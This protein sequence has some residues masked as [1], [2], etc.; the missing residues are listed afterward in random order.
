[1]ELVKTFTILNV[2]VDTRLEI[3][4]TSVT[5]T[6]QRRTLIFKKLS[7]EYARHTV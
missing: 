1:M 2:T 3:M 7:S 5:N 6:L 4:F